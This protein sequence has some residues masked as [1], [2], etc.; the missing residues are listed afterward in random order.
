MAGKEEQKNI[1]SIMNSWIND[2]GGPQR[3][4][5]ETGVRHRVAGVH[6]CQEDGDET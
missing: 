4:L 1:P 6:P 2:T 5:A 3:D